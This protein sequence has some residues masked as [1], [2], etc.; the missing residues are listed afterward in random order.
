M[1]S[2]RSKHVT[3][4]HSAVDVRIL[5]EFTIVWLLTMFKV[6]FSG[7]DGSVAGARATSSVFITG[8]MESIDGMN[9]APL[10]FPWS[11]NLQSNLIPSDGVQALL[12]KLFFA[13]IF[14]VRW[15]FCLWQQLRS[16]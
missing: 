3:C 6:Y 11:Q 16:I 13:G 1:A 2:S 12:N 4:T 8:F 15:R 5:E 14:A 10:R 9:A 7:R